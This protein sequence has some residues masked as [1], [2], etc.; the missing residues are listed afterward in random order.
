MIGKHTGHKATGVLCTQAEWFDAEH[1]TL[2]SF[3][4]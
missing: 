3:G 1:N 4:M 2:V